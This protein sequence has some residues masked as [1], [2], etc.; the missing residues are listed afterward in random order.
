MLTAWQ[1]PE[2]IQYWLIIIIIIIRVVCSTVISTPQ[3]G[4]QPTPSIPVCFQ[5]LSVFR[6]AS[7]LFILGYWLPNVF[8]VYISFCLL[9]LSLARLSSQSFV[10][11]KGI[12]IILALCISLWTGGIR[13]IL[14]SS[15]PPWWCGLGRRWRGAYESIS[16]MWPVFSSVVLVGDGEEL[17]KAS[18]SC[19]LY[20]LL[21]SW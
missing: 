14:C 20:S 21:W 18:H 10:N 8:F 13:K 1:Q 6:I 3:M 7:S 19:G 9:V 17:T 4:M 12:H 5:V 11:M 15:F 2:T 16:F